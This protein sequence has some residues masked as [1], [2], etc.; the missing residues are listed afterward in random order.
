[1]NKVVL[2]SGFPSVGKSQLVNAAASQGILAVNLEA[3]PHEPYS[4]EKA[5]LRKA[6]DDFTQGDDVAFIHT[7]RELPSELILLE[8]GFP[9]GL[10]TWVERLHRA[11]V[12]TWWLDGDS[13]AARRYHADAGKNLPAFDRQVA[14]IKAH[15]GGLKS[16]YGSRR[17]MRLSA[18]GTFL[19]DDAVLS[20]LFG[21]DWKR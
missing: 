20:T 21:K 2:L 18:D 1:M 11:G 15:E 8:W 19:S 17:I 13:T 4:L 12:D 10:I 9:L 5:G 14:D 16:F 3:K 6:W 7:L